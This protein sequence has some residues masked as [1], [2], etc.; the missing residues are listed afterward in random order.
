VGQLPRPLAGLVGRDSERQVLNE[1]LAER[2]LVTLCGPAGVGKTRLAV[3]VAWDVVDWLTDGVSM[4]ELAGISDLAAV[5]AMT[6]AALRVPETAAGGPLE[7]LVAVLA[8]REQLLVLDNCEHLLDA[9]ADLVTAVLARTTGV[10]VLATSR[11]PLRIGGEAVF[12]LDPLSLPDR[13]ATGAGDAVA[14]FVAR[15][16]EANHRFVLSASDASSAAE[17]VGRLDGLPLAI[18]LV[19]ANASAFSTSELLERVE[20]HPELLVRRELSGTRR[21]QSLWAAI[22]WSDALLTSQQRRALYGLSVF[23]G[24]CTIGSAEQVCIGPGDFSGGQFSEAVSALVDKSLVSV[25]LS[26]DGTRYNLLDTVRR[27]AAEQLA[28]AG[29][30]GKLHTAFL[31]WVVE[32]ADEAGAGLDGPEWSAW[33]G[34]LDAEID[35]LAAGLSWAVHHDAPAALLLARRLS[36][37]WRTVGRLAE[38]RRWL[39]AALAANADASPL[40]SAAALIELGLI[41]QE[42]FDVTGSLGIHRRAVDAARAADDDG[43]LIRANVGMAQALRDSGDYTEAAG[44]AQLALDLARARADRLGAARA[45]AALAFIRVYGG[46]YDDAKADGEQAVQLL[47]EWETRDGA[48]EPIAAAAVANCFA[49]DLEAADAHAS[50]ALA[51]AEQRGSPF[52]RAW[53]HSMLANIAGLLGDAGKEIEHGLRCLE[54]SLDIASRR[55]LCNA[56]MGLAQASGL[57]GNYELGATLAAAVGAIAHREGFALPPGFARYLRLDLY[58]SSFGIEPGP[59]SLAYER[60]KTMDTADVVQ[61]ARTVTGLL[62]DDSPRGV[63]AAR[64]SPRECD[65]VRLVAEGLTDAQI[66][67][68]LCISIRTVRSHLDRIRDKTG[69]RRRPDLTRLAATLGLPTT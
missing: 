5:P 19:A 17:L 3:E 50:R 64:L 44:A 27:Y 21:H 14:L 22:E 6:A 65:L 61:L 42:Q 57:L 46:A 12:R 58:A 33:R 4:V 48:W 55:T 56:L 31:E 69:A 63:S 26:P 34:R 29:D 35:N 28:L 18:E 1:L 68:R 9:V 13:A 43:L 60:G 8:Q 66:G 67:D 32:F 47:G 39:E 24:G 38:G 30:A 45:L 52:Q 62:G 54:L 59:L 25:R 49:G 10:R 7:A 23:A 2:R 11:E 40:E 41:A 36:R 16:S 51:L 20:D 37:W 15:A 53:A